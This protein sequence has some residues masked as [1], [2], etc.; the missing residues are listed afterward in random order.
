MGLKYSWIDLKFVSDVEDLGHPLYSLLIN[1]ET[2]S[3]VLFALGSQWEQWIFR[4]LYS[5]FL[6]KTQMTNQGAHFKINMR[7]SASIA[8]LGLSSQFKM[9]L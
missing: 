2:P 3:S 1:R 5:F 4:P 7:L 8:T 9:L 6:C